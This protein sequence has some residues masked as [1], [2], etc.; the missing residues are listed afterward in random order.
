MRNIIIETGEEEELLVDLDTEITAELKLEGIARNL[1]RHLNNYRKKLNLSTKNRIDLY[2]TTN[3]KE[4]IEALETHE[5][6]IKKLIQADNIIKSVEDKME[7]KK[8]KIDNNVIEAYIEVK[9]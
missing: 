7:V 3:N 5:E 1:I 4:V 2:L 6:R 9:N 8:F